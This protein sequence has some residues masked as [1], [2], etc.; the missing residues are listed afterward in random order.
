[1]KR[2]PITLIAFF[3][4]LF[5]GV[6]LSASV[7]AQTVKKSTLTGEIIS[8]SAVAPNG[9]NDRVILTTPNEGAFV[10][11]QFC[12]Q[13]V[14]PASL[15]DLR[16]NTFGPIAKEDCVTYTPGISLPPDENLVCV[17]VP[18]AGNANKVCTVTG[19]LVKH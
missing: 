19:I 8:A 13:S 17:N 14:P 7:E 15:A 6:L 4:V 18:P 12:A 10:L 1:M 11:T 2:L 3:A 16:G 5:F 9:T